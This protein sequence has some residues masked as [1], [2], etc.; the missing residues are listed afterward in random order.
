MWV[1]DQPFTHSKLS[2]T[3]AVKRV[4]SERHNHL[5]VIV[6]SMQSTTHITTLSDNVQS[7]WATA[8]IIERLC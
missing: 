8:L 7:P 4:Q 1:V 6:I 3:T 5:H 2:S